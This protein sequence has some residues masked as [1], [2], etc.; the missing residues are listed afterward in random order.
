MSA[1]STLRRVPPGRAGRLWLEHRLDVA[2]RGAE[3]L[4]HKLRI[5]HAERQRMSLR[6]AQTAL[7]WE[8][9]VREAETWLLRSV[10]LG[11]QRGLR[12]AQGGPFV[13]VEVRWAGSMGV[14]YPVEASCRLSSRSSDAVPDG[15]AALFQARDSYL[16]AV[17]AAAAHAA[18]QGALR[19][20]AAEERVTRRRLRAIEDRWVPRLRGAL[21]E[22]RLALEE[23][24]HA[25][26]IRLRWAAA[27]GDGARRGTSSRGTGTA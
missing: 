19:V 7:T 16:R 13:D 3:L 1:V 21:A 4:D 14:R 22:A 27:A 6:E 23:Q 25:D 15:S 20:V 17:Q 9:A 26:G 5:L 10:L 11:G 24:E 2:E 8:A 12:L 18:A